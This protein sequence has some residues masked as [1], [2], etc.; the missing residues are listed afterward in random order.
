MARPLESVSSVRVSLTV[1]TKQDTEAGPR[2]RCSIW[3]NVNSQLPITNSQELQT[4]K[5]SGVP[6]RL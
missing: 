3:D 1:R 6:G 4:P 5:R 2:A